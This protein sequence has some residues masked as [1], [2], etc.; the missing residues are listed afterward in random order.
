MR[1]R[2]RTLLIVLALGPVVLAWGIPAV[3][4][5]LS[6]PAIYMPALDFT[7]RVMDKQ[8]YLTTAAVGDGKLVIGKISYG[9]VKAGDQIRL[10]PGDNVFVNGQRRWPE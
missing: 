4:S 2:L 3:L 10:G 8:P 7:S 9:P 5:R 6:V 1:F